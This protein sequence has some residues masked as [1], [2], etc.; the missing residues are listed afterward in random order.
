ML[1]LEMPSAWNRVR[2]LETSTKLAN[3]R[4]RD[5]TSTPR[6]F[7]EIRTGSLSRSI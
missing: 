6:L 5:V 4:R 1:E 7:P 2:V 3:R